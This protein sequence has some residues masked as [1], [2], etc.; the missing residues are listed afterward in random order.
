MKADLFGH[1]ARALRLHGIRVYAWMPT[2]SVVFA[3]RRETESL[4]VRR[5]ASKGRAGS[6]APT[7]GSY[8]RL[9][10]F[11]DAAREKVALLYEDLAINAPLS[12]IL[13][14]DDAYLDEDEDYSPAARAALELAVGRPSAA[15]PSTLSAAERRV[16]TSLKTQKLIDWTQAL[17][18]AVHRYRPFAKAARTLYAP[19]LIEPESETW[20]AQNYQQSLAAY[21][22]VV[23]LA[24]PLMENADDATAWLRSLV[25]AARRDPRGLDKTVFKVQTVDWKNGG[26][27]VPTGAVRD[28]LRALLTA[29]AKHIAYYPD[30]L[31]DDC[32]RQSEIRELIS[33]EEFP[34]TKP[35]NEQ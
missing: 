19:V 5:F 18:T 14:Q 27:C 23:V 6:T 26:R 10:P 28:W 34:F 13:F 30:N 1:V 3:D 21:D 15:A 25:Q 33:T 4:R 8:L 22:E 35:V 20:F 9:S 11:S 7:R 24:Y 31:F 32:P 12:G 16:W 2:L 17:M 29:G